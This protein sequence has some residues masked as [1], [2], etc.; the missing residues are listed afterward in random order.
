MYR[1]IVK[2][3]NLEKSKRSIFWNGGSR[4]EKGNGTLDHVIKCVSVLS[5]LGQDLAKPTRVLNWD[6]ATLRK[7]TDY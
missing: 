5:T 3:I 6:R 2:Y 7:C 1:Y 4:K